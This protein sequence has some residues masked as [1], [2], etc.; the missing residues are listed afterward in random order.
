MFD[1]I[2]GLPV[3]VLVIHAVVVLV[4]LGAA[5][6]AAIAIVPP[7]RQRFGVAVLGITTAGLLAVPVATQSGKKLEAR[8]NAGGIVAKQI[9]HHRDMGNLVLYPTLALWILAAALIL[10]DRRGR[11]GRPVIAVVA[12]LAVLA[13]GAATAQVAITGH[14]GSTAVWSCTIGSSACK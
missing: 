10:L 8:L 12:V 4:P 3:H 7:W 6:V 2:L 5:G 1:T 9:K 14:L 13:A 11:T